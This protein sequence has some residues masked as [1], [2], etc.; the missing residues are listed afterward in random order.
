MALKPED[1]VL[2]KNLCAW[3]VYFPRVEGGGDIRI[4]ENGTSRLTVEEI[5]SQVHA[6]NKMFVGE[7]GLGSNARLY[8]DNKELRVQLDFERGAD[9][10]EEDEFAPPVK[11]KVLTED[12][13]KKILAI[14]TQA[15]FEKRVK[16]DVVTTAE[17][18]KL[19]EVAGKTGLN[20]HKKLTFI[21]EY[22]ELKVVTK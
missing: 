19:V 20:D 15:A 9:V 14:K 6:N 13:V 5:E 7:D 11:Q 17:K 2:V 21:E 12:I 22:A 4:V 8:I 1:K 18:A 16:E 3:P 10:A